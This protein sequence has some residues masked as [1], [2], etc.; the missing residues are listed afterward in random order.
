MLTLPGAVKLYSSTIPSTRSSG[1]PGCSEMVTVRPFRGPPTIFI[2]SSPPPVLSVYPTTPDR[3]CGPSSDG[4]NSFHTICRLDPPLF[5]YRPRAFVSYHSLTVLNPPSYQTVKGGLRGANADGQCH[6]PA[7]DRRSPPPTK[8]C[9]ARSQAGS[10]SGSGSA[11]ATD[12]PASSSTP[13]R[14]QK[15]PNGSS[16]SRSALKRAKMGTSSV[17][18]RWWGT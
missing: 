11:A 10:G 12:S 15:L 2:A 5:S 13:M 6:G 14:W 4:P 8:S 3:A 17:T 7:N 18:T 16:G 1:P 9:R